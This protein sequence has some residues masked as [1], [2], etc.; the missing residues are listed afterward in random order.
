[1]DE[2]IY[3]TGA[4]IISAIGNDKQEVLCSLQNKCS[5]IGTMRY[6]QS[7]HT[8]LP[9]G[10]VKLSDD[11][12]RKKLSLGSNIPANRT[13]LMGTIAMK[14]AL[15]DAGLLSPD[16]NLLA[17]ASNLL[18]LSG[19]TVGGMD[20]TERCFL[21]LQRSDENLQILATHDCGSTT[22]LQA[23]YFGI[24]HDNVMT[25]STAC[26]SAAN[27]MIVGANL[28]KTGKADIVIAGGSEAITKFHLNGFNSLL[29]LDHDQCRPFDATRVGLNLGEGAAYLILESARSVCRRGVTP[30]GELLGYGNACDAFHQTASSPNGEGAYLAM[31]EALK[32]AGLTADDI[33]YVNA[34][35]TGTPN[36]D[37]SE[38]VALTRIFN[39]RLPLVSS[40]KSFTGHTTSASGAVEAVICLLALNHQFVPGNLG[41]K[42]QMPDG[43]TPTLGESHFELTNVMCNSFGFG[44]NDSSIILTRYCGNLAPAYERKLRPVYIRAVCKYTP[45]GVLEDLRNFISPIEARRMC[46]LLKTALVTSM[47]VLR[48]AEIE[49]PDGIFIGTKFGMLS[50]SEKFLQQMCAEGENS[51]GPTLFM[52]STHNTI[53][54]MLALRTRCHGYNITYTQGDK[55][56]SCSLRDAAMQIALG[57]INNALVGC[58]DESTPLFS[59]MFKRLTGEYIVPGEYSTSIVLTSSAD[60]AIEEFKDF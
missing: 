26:S 48:D 23:D 7:E 4:G 29:I 49:T 3:I 27:A 1:M 47:S 30:I 40:T 19:T 39:D 45:D 54:G 24:P 8:E 37:V 57:N 52:Q 43:I 14:E 38:S 10:E 35:G 46:R 20:Y 42:H 28:I 53:A 59:D 12:M 58:H 51:L 36:N 60:G 21:D 11:Q 13:S 55:S 56:L 9:V 15:S 6:L 31:A 25:I 41:W 5:G 17:D 44:G 16:T 34:H 33:Q 32:M 22:L 50:N 2:P 18:L